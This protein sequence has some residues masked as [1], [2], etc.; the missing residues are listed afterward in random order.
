[1]ALIRTMQSKVER[2]KQPDMSRS[3]WHV[4]KK[5]REAG[6]DSDDEDDGLPSC[7]WMSKTPASAVN[8]GW[9]RRI[10]DKNEIEV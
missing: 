9:G 10:Y 7:D 1:M 4:W 6:N 2:R 3:K 5:Y 8:V